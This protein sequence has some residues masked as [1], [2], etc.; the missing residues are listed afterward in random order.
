MVDSQ[1]H[2]ASFLFFFF[3]KIMVEYTEYKIYHF[4]ARHSAVCLKSQLLREQKLGRSWFMASQ[5]KN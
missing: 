5:A 3:C 1:S 4:M 2:G